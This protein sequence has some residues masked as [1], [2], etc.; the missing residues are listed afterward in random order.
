MSKKI[1]KLSINLLKEQWAPLF[2]LFFVV[3]SS[4]KYD[5]A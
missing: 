1:K 2:F 4:I 3:F 5:G